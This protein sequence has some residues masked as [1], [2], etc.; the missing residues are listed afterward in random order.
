MAWPDSNTQGPHIAADNRGSG[1]QYVTEGHGDQNVAYGNGVQY[2]LHAYYYNFTP[3]ISWL[4]GQWDL[5]ALNFRRHHSEY[6]SQREPGTGGWVLSSKVFQS[7]KSPSTTSRFLQLHGN[8]GSGKTILVS[9]IVDT[10]LEEI[11]GRN[12]VACIYFYS[13]GEDHKPPEYIWATLL[14]QLLQN[15][16]YETLAQEV[17]DEFNMSLQGSTTLHSSQYLHLF[18]A[19][20]ATLKTVYLVIDDLD[21]FP[22]VPGRSSRQM[23]MNDL[24]GMPYNVRVLFTSKQA[25]PYQ[26]LRIEPKKSDIETYVRSRVQSNAVLNGER[27]TAIHRQEVIEEVTRV[28]LTSKI[29]LLARLHMDNLSK[30]GTLADIMAAL[31][32]LPDSSHNAFEAS[33]QQITKKPEFQSS[34]ARHV[35]TWVA[36]VKSDLNAEQIRDS[37]AI[38]RSKGIRFQ[39]HRPSTDSVLSV[40]AGLVIRDTSNDSLR[41]VHES[42][43][44]H[45]EQHGIISQDAELEVTTRNWCTHLGCLGQKIDPGTDALVL[46]FLKDS[47]KLT[48]AFRHIDE[49]KDRGLDGMTG[50]HAAM[51]YNIPSWANRLIKIGVDVNAKCRD[52]Q[53]AVHW[54]VRYGRRKLLKLLI[55]NSADLNMQD[56]AGDTPLHK[57]LMGSTSHG[58]DIVQDLVKSGARFDI[59]GNEGLSPL[60]SAIK[61]GPTSIADIFVKNQVDVNAESYEDCTSLRHVFCSGPDVV[62]GGVGKTARSGTPDG[63]LRQAVESHARYLMKRLLWRGVDLNRPSAKDEWTPL[64]DA[65]ERQDV[66]TVQLLAEHGAEVNIR[67]KDGS[68]PLIEAVKFRNQKLVWALLNRGARPDERNDK[69]W[70]AL[71]YAIKNGDRAI[72][73]LLVTN[74]ADLTFEGKNIPNALEL[75][76]KCRDLSVAWLLCEHGASPGAADD[77]G[78]TALH[79]ASNRGSLAAVRFLVDRGVDVDARDR[80]GRTPLML[81]A[82]LG[83]EVAVRQLVA[84]GANVNTQ[85]ASGWTAE[86]YAGGHA[87]IQSFLRNKLRL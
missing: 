17:M 16:G 54:A 15:H 55:R 82:Q 24:K 85:N 28:T 29:F 44:E 26:Q 13:Q 76:L 12:D 1:S 35:L 73:W 74:T 87:G 52:G 86:D 80:D 11:R 67:T 22:D 48:R 81:A 63:L 57:A 69:G 51:H 62:G 7:W 10:I 5:S 45:L 8:L 9:L 27:A 14:A 68:T 78:T 60:T 6:C 2:N 23:I 58:A 33:I 25:G 83:K 70:P 34:L 66:D 42:V 77:R 64:M 43:Q 56:R 47:S 61:Y 32:Q 46:K 37:F 84:E 3:V 40:C 49:T 65:V 53:T 79:R 30:Q 75:A 39:D 4:M 18:N 59:P 71:F 19:Q 21:S 41:L 72:V 20:V 38:Q 31:R 36:H 50:L